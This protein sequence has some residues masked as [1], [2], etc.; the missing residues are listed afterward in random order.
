MVHTVEGVDRRGL[1]MMA[2]AAGVSLLAPRLGWAKAR[3]FGGDLSNVSAVIDRQQ[4]EALKRPQDWIALPTI[5]A[6]LGYA[7]FLYA[8]AGT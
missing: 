4:P 7:E 5:G 3:G 2:A 6:T 8:L 1:M